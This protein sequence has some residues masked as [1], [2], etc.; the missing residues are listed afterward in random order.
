M[1]GWDGVT[2]VGVGIADRGFSIGIDDV[3]ASK[4]LN[5]EKQQVMDKNYAK[6]EQLLRD[7]KNG[8][9][10]ASP[11]CSVET[12]LEVGSSLSLSLSLALSL[13]P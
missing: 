4:E 8:N 3:Q 1:C 12:T 11:G 6:C 5:E 7:W 10:E 13:T 9:L 2:D